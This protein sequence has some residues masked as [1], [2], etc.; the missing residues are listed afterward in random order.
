VTINANG[1]LSGNGTL[2][3][4]INHGTIKPG[5]SIGTITINGNYTQT[6]TYELELDSNG[7]SD[8][9]N[10]TGTA[11]LGGTLTVLPLSPVGTFIPGTIYTILTAANVN[12]TFQQILNPNMLKFHLIY[13]GTQVQLVM[14]G[15]SFAGTVANNGDANASSIAQYLDGL[16]V[17]PASDLGRVLTLING[18][19][20]P[21]AIAEA[22]S[23]IQPNALV[24]LSDLIYALSHRGSIAALQEIYAI[25]TVDQVDQ[26]LRSNQATT[27][28]FADQFVAFMGQTSQSVSAQLDQVWNR[29]PQKTYDVLTIAPSQQQLPHDLR[30][31]FGKANFWLQ[32]TGH[33]LHHKRQGPSIGV[34]SRSAVTSGGID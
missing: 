19:G 33:Y 32:Q 30:V 15:Q 24:S 26:S 14:N 27:K 17:D 8:R 6:G 1:R 3:N 23:R 31:K 16:Q 7:T 13:S 4:V 20:D 9:I 2:A 12:G 5:N 34:Q 11:S 25:H 21:A 18:L 22:L 10:V 29:H 28:D